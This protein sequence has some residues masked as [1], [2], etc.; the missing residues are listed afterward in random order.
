[1]CPL[2]A[3]GPGAWDTTGGKPTS[4]GLFFLKRSYRSL[5]LLSLALITELEN[6]R[7]TQTETKI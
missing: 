2:L 4:V 5:T 1:M 3:W 7:L 6:Q